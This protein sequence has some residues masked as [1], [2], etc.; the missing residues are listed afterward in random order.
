M[1]KSRFAE[2]KITKWARVSWAFVDQSLAA[3]ANTRPVSHVA[4]PND[5]C[6]AQTQVRH[7]GHWRAAARRQDLA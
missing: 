7:I 6:F 5:T 4:Q 2:D 1:Q 3:L